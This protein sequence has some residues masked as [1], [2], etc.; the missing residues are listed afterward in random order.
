MKSGVW[1]VERKVEWKVDEA[2]M[3]RMECRA[4]SG[5]ELRA[6]CGGD[7]RVENGW[8]GDSREESGESS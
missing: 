1:R 7:W 6:E 8:N 2:G 5:E 4:K 3:R